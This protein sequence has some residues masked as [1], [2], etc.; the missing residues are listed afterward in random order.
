MS[1]TIQPTGQLNF[2]IIQSGVFKG[3]RIKLKPVQPM[4][5]S[6]AMDSVEVPKRPTYETKTASGKVQVQPY[7]EKVAEETEGGKTIWTYYQEELQRALGEQNNKVVTAILAVGTEFEIPA[8]GSWRE[9]QEALGIPIPTNPIL[10]RAHF[11][12]TV[13]EDPAELNDITAKI[14]RLTGVSEEVIR[15]AEGTF[16]RAIRDEPERPEP[17]ALARPNPSENSS[18]QLA[19][20]PTL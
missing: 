19:S 14:M 4:L 15:Q 13:L 5:I 20:Q 3:F 9:D 1:D 10:L 12:L 8:G 18:G 6:K 7:D 17:M 16:Q 2:H 11:L